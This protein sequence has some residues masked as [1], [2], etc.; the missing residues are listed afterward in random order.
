[1]N[2]HAALGSS[3]RASP[4]RTETSPSGWSLAIFVTAV[5]A[6][7]GAA[8]LAV[9]ALG[10]L[11]SMAT[12]LTDVSA[13]MSHLESMD[14]KLTQTNRSLELTNLHLARM[15]RQAALAGVQ[16]A[17]MERTMSGLTGLTAGMSAELHAM[18]SDIHVMSHKISGSFLF[19]SVK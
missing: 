2:A 16:L 17:S 10:A 6:L 9:Y 4:G 18:G 3:Y 12:T 11:R 14:A 8:V 7:V 1:M 19:R 5:V 15:D 13:Q